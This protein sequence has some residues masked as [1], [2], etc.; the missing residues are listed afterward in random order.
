MADPQTPFRVFMT[1]EFRGGTPPRL[2][3]VLFV[4]L[5][6]VIQSFQHAAQIRNAK[7]ERNFFVFTRVA[8]SQKVPDF[9]S[10]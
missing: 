10:G 8:I 1:R 3:L 4:I 5:L 6:S 9:E 2:T 7:V